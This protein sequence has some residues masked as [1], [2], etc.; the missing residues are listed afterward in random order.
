MLCRRVLSGASLVEACVGSE[1]GAWMKRLYSLF[2]YDVAVIAIFVAVA[3]FLTAE[4][5][6]FEHFYRFSGANPHLRLGELAIL[7]TMLSMVFIFLGIRKCLKARKAYAQ[8]ERALQEREDALEK[9]RE[10][11]R[12][13]EVTGL[14]NRKGCLEFLHESLV[15]SRSSGGKIAVLLVDVDRFKV[16]NDHYGHR[17][18]DKLLSFFGQRL[19]GLIRQTDYIGRSGGDQFAIILN[20]L[21][22]YSDAA[23][24]ARKI[25]DGLADP[26]LID[27]ENVHMTCSIGIAFSPQDSSECSQLLHDAGLA[28]YQAKASGRSLYRFYTSVLQAEV[29]GRLALEKGL[30]EAIRNEEF[31]PWFQPQYEL[32]SLNL[33]GFEALARWNHPTRGVLAPGQ[34]ID[35]AEETGLIIQIGELVLEKA[36]AHLQAMQKLSGQPL[37]MSVNLSPRQ[38]ESAELVPFVRNILGKYCIDPGN[39]VLEITENLL[40]QKT[41]EVLETL[42]E[43]KSLG[44]HIALDDFGT[45]YSAIAYL[46]QFHF[47]QIK[48]DRSF[49]RH[50]HKNG[51][52]IRLVK[53]MLG[54]ATHLGMDIV[55]EGIEVN[56]QLSAL[57]DLECPLGQ[58]YLF[59]KPVKYGE[60]EQLILKNEQHLVDSRLD[61]IED[62]QPVIAIAG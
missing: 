12:F 4:L 27:D 40:L 32:K 8:L 61:L 56:E 7:M 25:I 30:R 20:H 23:R 60:A 31:E 9:A 36:C 24:V 55:A 45:G 15:R 54:I 42:A 28:M 17:E 2:D 41:G 10:Q 13:D 35:L 29:V 19:Q 33:I 53:L 43:L 11:A 22:D 62:E 34:F 16:V 14:L 5:V 38:L 39:L 6:L 44:I 49:I 58:G 1:V 18:G 21:N 52:D 37:K 47:D 26:F 48:I 3:I 46:Q 51:K 57:R 50:V 59:S